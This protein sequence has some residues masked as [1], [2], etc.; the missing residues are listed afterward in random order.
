MAL[1][2]YQIKKQEFDFKIWFRA[3]KVTGLS[4]NGLQDQ[5]DIKQRKKEIGM[6]YN[7]RELLQ[8]KEVSF[9]P[10]GRPP[11]MFHA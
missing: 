4:R 9:W 8:E 6:Y 3:R 11:Q 10:L 1:F 7:K 5:V 2:K